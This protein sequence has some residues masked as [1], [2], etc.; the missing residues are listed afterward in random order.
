M[1]N[2]ENIHPQIREGCQHRYTNQNFADAVS[3]AFVELNDSVKKYIKSLYEI[4]HDGAD[5]FRKVFSTKSSILKFNNND[6]ETAKNIQEGYLQIFAG[7]W[8]GIRNPKA[9]Q[10]IDISPLEAMEMIVIASHLFRMFDKA[11]G[12]N[13]IELKYFDENTI[14]GLNNDSFL[15]VGDIRRWLKIDNVVHHIHDGN[16]Y[17]KIMQLNSKL[18]NP[19]KVTSEYFKNLTLGPQ[20]IS[21]LR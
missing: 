5:L 12:N 16:T 11:K 21:K 4:E 17:R 6:D 2:W 15:S 1:I 3:F 10:N 18:I 14:K 7:T 9:H 8:I 13:F 20:I 19:T